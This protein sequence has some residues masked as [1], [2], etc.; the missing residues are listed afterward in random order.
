MPEKKK[1][2]DEVPA[3]GRPISAEEAGLP[4]EPEATAEEWAIIREAF[5]ELEALL[6]R[7]RAQEMSG[8]QRMRALVN[9]ERFADVGATVEEEALVKRL[10]ARLGGMKRL[11]ENVNRYIWNM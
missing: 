4:T 1:L 3:L 6:L 8:V 5:G 11:C 7:R 10:A 2:P 9:C